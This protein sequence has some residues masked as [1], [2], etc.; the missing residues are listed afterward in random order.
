MAIAETPDRA[1]GSMRHNA[2]AA[3]ESIGRDA[4][5]AA[6]TATGAARDAGAALSKELTD[7]YNDVLDFVS[8]HD[9]RDDPGVSAL[10]QKIE[11]RLSAV[12]ESVADATRQVSRQAGR[13]VHVAD[14]YAHNEPWRVA[15]V[16]AL[17]GVAVGVLLSRR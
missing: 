8:R 7:V 16:A 17:I 11:R 5:H 15:G 2:A 1:A 6:D 14:E 13:A 4:R 10:K 9:L 3:A 12:R